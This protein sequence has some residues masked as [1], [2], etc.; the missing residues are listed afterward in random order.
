MSFETRGAVM[1]LEVRVPQGAATDPSAAAAV[2]EA[3]ARGRMVLE[4]PGQGRVWS[5]ASGPGV[6]G[7]VAFP[8]A[9]EALRLLH[10]LRT[11]LRS[12][13]SRPKLTVV[14]GIGRGDEV[15]GT[16]LAGE[17]FRGLGKRGRIRTRV[18]TGEPKADQVLSALCR[19]L[20]T[21]HTGWTAAQWQAV[22]RRDGG[23]T[24]QQIGE[25][26]G[27]AYQNVSKRLIAARYDLYCDVQNAAGL[28]LAEPALG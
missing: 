14:A 23:G 21:L 1:L 4:S 22:Y 17:A 2:A 16:R 13:P 25:E 15:E 24:L 18:L 9:G 6:S 26:L 27:I 20:D 3:L 19:T 12:D 11:E 10:R 7:S 8:D 5:P 28:V